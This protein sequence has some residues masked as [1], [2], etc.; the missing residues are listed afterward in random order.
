VENLM[1]KIEHVGNG[2][3]V[4]LEPIEPPDGVE[5]NVHVYAYADFRSLEHLSYGLIRDDPRKGESEEVGEYGME[6]LAPYHQ[7]ND[8]LKEIGRSKHTFED[9][10]YVEVESEEDYDQVLEV[11]DIDE[12]DSAWEGPGLYDFR[13]SPPASAGSVEDYELE[14]MEDAADQAFD[15]MFQGEEWEDVYR[16]LAGDEEED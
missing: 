4:D 10:P 16:N 8:A 2:R 13:D 15:F 6:P 1:A 14:S 12:E 7:F 9:V 5:N 3:F 11:L